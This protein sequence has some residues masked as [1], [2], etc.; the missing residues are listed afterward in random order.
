MH[1]NQIL[2]FS[3][4][5]DNE[6]FQN[7]LD[8]AYRRAEDL[9]ENEDGY[10]DRSLASKGITA[11]YRDSRYKKKVRLIVNTHLLLDD[12][13]DTDKL[14][15][16]L[17]RWIAEYF[18]SKYH[19]ADFN[20]SGVSFVADIDVGT[21][22]KTQ[23]YLKAIKRIG[24]VKGFSPID[25]ECFDDG[26]SFCLSGNSN[27]IDFLLY[28]LE[29]AVMKRSDSKDTDRKD[30]KP[31][32]GVLRAEVRLTKGKAIRA[33]SDAGDAQE[34]IGDLSKRCR[35]VFLDTFAQVIPFG[36]YYKKNKAV[37]IIRKEIADSMMR[38]KMLRLLALIPEKKSL[39]L[40]QKSLNC[41]NIEKVMA[42]FAKISLSP[43]TI[44]KRQDVKYLENIY[45][46]ILG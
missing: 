27:G 5:L 14:L 9:E 43:V 46:Y 21:R 39:H 34:Q 28:D 1:V 17:D 44:S 16:K 10:I 11:I 42:A 2:E 7:V 31:I 15:Q 22:S 32:K 30:M 38:K 19:L 40:A 36:N 45:E 24:R 13:S 8:S 4:M 6:K 3:M 41:R 35:D 23:A 37:E 25:Y 20:L 12:V 18:N 26:F 29:S 33:Y